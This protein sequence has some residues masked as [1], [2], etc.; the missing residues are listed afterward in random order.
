MTRR[1]VAV[2]CVPETG[3]LARIRV[4]VRQLVAAG[5]EVVVLSHARYRD[6]V[7]GEGAGFFDLYGRYPI[8]EADAE[9]HPVSCR[10]VTHAGV[11]AERVVGDLRE[12][13]P[14]LV[15]YDSFSVVGLVAARRLD[16]PHVCVLS[17]HNPDPARMLASLARDSRVSIADC[18]TRAVDELRDAWGWAD[19]SP[20]SFVDTLSPHLNVYC[21]PPAYLTAEERAVFEPI[22]FLGSL[23]SLEP[24]PPGPAAFPEAD[25]KIYVSFG[26]V[27]WRYFGARADEALDAIGRALGGR[28]DVRLLVSLGGGGH[29][30]PASLEAPNIEVRDYVDQWRVLHEADV[31]VTHHGLNSTHEAAAC[32]VPMIS[33][34]I[35]WDQPALAARCAELGIAVPLGDDVERALTAAGAARPRMARAQA[36]ERDVIAARPAAIERILAIR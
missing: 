11:F 14:D 21:E 30:P 35:F 28:T 26:T 6:I 31:F 18:C 8:E 9:S 15:V 4:V 3:H 5:C 34:P 20:F 7:E 32:G 36:W 27:I 10:H 16:L 12:I 29:T 17:G 2:F 23:A 24:P 33:H 22:V 13:G 25:H 19:V 1:K